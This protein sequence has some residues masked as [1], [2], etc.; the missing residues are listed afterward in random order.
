MRV[1][2]ST[3]SARASRSTLPCDV[4]APAL[5]IADV[6]RMEAGLLRETFRRDGAVPTPAPSRHAREDDAS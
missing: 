6:A 1:G 2:R 5:D 3:V 4:A